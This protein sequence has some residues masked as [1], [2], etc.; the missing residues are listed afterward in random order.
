MGWTLSWL[1]GL[2][3]C[4]LLPWPA[5][6]QAPPVRDAAELQQTLDQLQVV[7]SVLYLAAHPDDENNAL[8]AYFSKGRHLWTSYL[9][10]NRGGGGQNRIGA[11]RG[12]LLAALRTQELLAARRLDGA[13]QVFTRVV[14]FGYSKTPQETL[15]IWGHD[16]ALADVVWTL[17]KLR[18]DVIVMDIAMPILNGFEATRQILRVSPST[19]VLVLSAHSDDEYVAKMAAVGASGYVVKQNSG[20]T[21]VKAIKEIVNGEPYFSNPGSRLQEMARRARENGGRSGPANSQ[22]TSREAEVLQLVAEG[23]SNKQVASEL[24]ISIKTVEKHRQRLMDKL[25]IH[26]TAGLTR[27]AIAAGVIESSVQVTVV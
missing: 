26:D 7:G 21:L 15:A 12:D 27:H 8:L 1:K 14:D 22:L 3:L 25:N 19:K 9:S 18:P 2:L 20:Q 13:D 24:A 4:L 16:A 6:G 5:P 17:R 11:E 10:L 23:S